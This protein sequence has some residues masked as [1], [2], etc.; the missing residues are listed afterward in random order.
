ML[1]FAA[2]I[3]RCRSKHRTA[4]LLL[5]ELE[6]RK[7]VR[8]KK[9]REEKRRE[10]RIEI[11]ENKKQGKCK[12]W[13]HRHEGTPERAALTCGTTS[14]ADPEVHIG[15]ENLQHF[16]AFGSPPHHSCPPAQPDFRVD[17]PSPLGSSP[18]SGELKEG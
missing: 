14:H 5:D 6:K 15:L 1:C 16:P 10:K 13:C 7:R 8:Q 2:W 3:S 18:S 17:P 11:E 12:P 4:V 9:L